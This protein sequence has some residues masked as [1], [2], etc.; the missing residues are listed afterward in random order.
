MGGGGVKEGVWGVGGGSGGDEE[1]NKEYG[2]S[3]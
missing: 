3:G 1:D 2:Q